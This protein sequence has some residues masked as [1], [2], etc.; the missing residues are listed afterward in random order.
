MEMLG[1][2][3]VVFQVVFTKFDKV[4]SQDFKDVLELSFNKMA[5]HANAYPEVLITS[6][7][8]KHGLEKLRGTICTLLSPS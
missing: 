6:S 4:K 7:Q 5:H 3:G 8:K 2:A 1:D